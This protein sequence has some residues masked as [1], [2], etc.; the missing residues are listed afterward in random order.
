MSGFK[1]LILPD[2]PGA[3]CVYTCVQNSSY[4]ENPFLGNREKSLTASIK[5]HCGSIFYN[6]TNTQ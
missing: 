1:L 4:S 2:F 3:D 6:V 5:F